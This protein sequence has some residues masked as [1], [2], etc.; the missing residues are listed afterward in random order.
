M[1]AINELF[2]TVISRKKANAIAE[3]QT[4]LGSNSKKDMI[5]ALGGI[6]GCKTWD[7][8]QAIRID[9]YNRLDDISQFFVRC[10]LNAD[11]FGDELSADLEYLKSNLQKLQK[12]IM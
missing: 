7:E 11:P 12:A 5:I 8:L 4:D 1:K 10:I 6:K 9:A 3:S 2:E